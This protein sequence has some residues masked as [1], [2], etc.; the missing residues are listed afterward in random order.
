MPFPTTPILDNFN[1]SDRTLDG[2]WNP[3]TGF[4]GNLSNCGIVSN[5][6]GDN[7]CS[8]VWLATVG[9]DCEAYLTIPTIPITN[10]VRVAARLTTATSTANGYSVDFRGAIPDILIM[11]WD[12]GN[13]TAIS[14]T[15]S[16][17]SNGDGIGIAC[18]G[19]TIQAWKR[20]SGIWSM[21]ASVNDS[22]YNTPGYLGFGMSIDVFFI[23]DFGGGTIPM[24]I[25]KI[26]YPTVASG[27]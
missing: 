4:D 25:P 17:L 3:N 15:S 26:S 24:V 20:S 22:T 8:T 7:P 23:D 5:Q 21:V 27:W 13:G 19:N 10:R 1:R 11:R 14:T 2:N 9:P 16:S 12:A 6:A 18:I